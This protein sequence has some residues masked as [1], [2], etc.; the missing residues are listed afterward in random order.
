MS[1]Q[2]DITRRLDDLETSLPSLPSN[3]VRLGRATVHRTNDIASAVGR[4]LSD[5]AGV[6]GHSAQT[7]MSTTA[8]QARSAAQRTI[9]AADRGVS[10]TIGQARAQGARAAESTRSEMDDAVADAVA[11]TEPIDLATLT[12]A[13]LYERAQ[14]LDVDGRSEMNK[15][16]LRAAVA[17]QS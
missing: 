10:E 3:L 13:E 9:D 15:S 14:E 17:S 16:Q 1:V 6:S 4:R 11:A 12:K 8:G 5:V 7:G 2:Q